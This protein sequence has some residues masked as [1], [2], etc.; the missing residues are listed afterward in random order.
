MKVLGLIPARG[1]SKGIPRKNIKNLCGKPLIAWTI[2][3]ALKSK[4]LDNVVVSTDDEEIADIAQKYGA[5]VPFMRPAELAGHSTPGIDTVLHAIDEL[6]DFDSVL[7]LQPTSPLRTSTDIDSIINFAF[8]KNANSVVSVCVA[9]VHPF[10]VYKTSESKLIS[11]TN[12]EFVP[13]RQNLPEAYS[14]NGALY[15]AQSPWLIK[16]R[17]FVTP[18]TFAF[19]MPKCNSYDIDD[20]DDWIVAEAILKERLTL[21][22]NEN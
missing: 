20:V 18:D 11:F 15:Y 19:Q 22:E 1:K 7:L 17:C 4:K 12:N 13:C 2:E 16:N 10:W 21:S 8:S 5:D 9:P 6:P 3:E 14:L